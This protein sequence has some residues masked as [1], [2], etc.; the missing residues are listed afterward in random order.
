[1]VHTTAPGC[2]D[3]ILKRPAPA[4]SS[5]HT[6]PRV[7]IVA[8]LFP[9]V[10]ETFVLNHVTGLIDLGYAVD[11]YA[12]GPEGLEDYSHHQLDEYQLAK[13]TTYLPKDPDCEEVARQFLER[14][15]CAV[16]CHFGLVSE[17]MS[18][19][20]EHLKTVPF[21]VTFHGK[22]IRLALAEGGQ[23]LQSTFERFD[24]FISICT[25]NRKR[26]EQLG[27]PPQQIVDLPNGVNTSAFAPGMRHSDGKIRI[28]TV[29][30]LHKDKN[31]R[32]ALRV[33]HRLAQSRL[34]FN[35]DVLGHGPDRPELESLIDELGLS[36][37]VTLHGQCSQEDVAKRL[38]QADIFFLPSRA[39]ASPV[40]VL[41]AQ[42]CALPVVATRVGGME[43]L[44]IDGSNGF[45][46]ESE[47]QDAAT[48]R[49]LHLAQNPDMRAVMGRKGRESIWKNHESRAL[50]RRC[51]AMYN[52]APA[53]AVSVIIPTFNRGKFLRK[54]IES[55]LSQSFQGFELIIVDDGST[56]NTRSVVD[57]YIQHFKGVIRYRHIDKKNAAAARNVGIHMSRGSFLAFLDSDDY[58]HEEKLAKQIAFLEA[59][60]LKGLV[61]TG[62][63]F[64]HMDEYVETD[65]LPIPTALARNSA[66]C[67]RGDHIIHM[68]VMGRREVFDNEGCFDE[69]FLTT[70]DTE[71][72]IRLAEKT[73]IGVLE[74]TLSFT[75]LHDNH[76]STGNL[77]QKYEDRMKLTEQLFRNRVS[78]IDTQIWRN[79]YNHTRY[80]LGQERYKSGEY[81]AAALLVTKS[82]CSNPLVGCA[83]FS[84]EDG[85]TKKANKL[86][87]PYLIVL[88]AFARQLLQAP[89]SGG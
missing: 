41:E 45:I 73:E 87:Q 83:R 76:L 12:F 14:D 31:V 80:A 19:L 44:V 25:Y 69:S 5:C 15:Y 24:W 33:M 57:D 36:S 40:C 10:S 6:R 2:E 81:G 52:S 55:V 4:S 66:D 75:R 82:L 3:Y 63:E 37:R 86:W 23:I 64:I 67:L 7:A 27:C 70:H 53:P 51:A 49:L 21:L 8:M 71:L 46:V 56:D 65:I 11:V 30:R 68:T 35:Y 26:L 39:E 48:N 16:H 9:T 32:F 34:E 47:D 1:M 61:H 78:G 29:A 74:Q 13:V 77:T 38:A 42:A 89:A 17:K 28:V 88:A 43:E 62:V 60:P 79:R 85:W 72:W 58:W 20:K 22:D 54:A 59:N 84:A 50:L 18:F